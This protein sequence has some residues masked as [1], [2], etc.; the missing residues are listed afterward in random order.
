V[1]QCPK[2]QNCGWLQL[3]TSCFSCNFLEALSIH[4]GCDGDGGCVEDGPAGWSP[5]GGEGEIPHGGQPRVDPL[6]RRSQVGDYCFS[7]VGGAGEIPHGG[8]PGVDPLTRGSQVWGYCFSLVGG[9]GEIP[10]G[11]QPGVDPLTQR[12]QV[13]DNCFSLYNFFKVDCEA[14]NHNLYYGNHFWPLIPDGI[15]LIF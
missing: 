1:V 7:L 3:I 15:H 11:G 10:H 2:P 9:A 12:S 5:V 4:A 6:T 14:R 8:Q 13:W